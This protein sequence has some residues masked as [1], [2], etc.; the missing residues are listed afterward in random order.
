MFPDDHMKR[1]IEVANRYYGPAVRAANRANEQYRRLQPQLQRLAE[2]Y[3]VLEEGP[4]RR[5]IQTFTFGRG[6]WHEASLLEM[7]ASDFRALVKDLVAKPDE[8]VKN[9]LDSV[10]PDYFRRNDY[11]ALRNMVEQWDL[12]SDWRE[13]VFKDAFHAHE[14]GKYTLSI[15]ALA[16][17]VEGM[18]RH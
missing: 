16:P 7:A 11:R 8:E 1:F 9:T 18:L 2:Q 4:R 3:R 14:N 17:Q 10:V 15:H 5:L 13:Q 12:Y 6:G